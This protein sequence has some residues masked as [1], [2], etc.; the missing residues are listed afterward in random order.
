MPLRCGEC[1]TAVDETAET[2]PRCGAPRTRFREA[3][4]GPGTVGSGSGNA[5]PPSEPGLG[6]RHSIGVYTRAGIGV[7]VVAAAFM[8]LAYYSKTSHLEDVRRKCIATFELSRRCDCLVNEIDKHTSAIS[9]VPFLRFISGL[10]QYK[11][12]DIIREASMTCVE[13]R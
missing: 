4:P 10:T 11:L 9:F 13:S 2:C 12:G 8:A 3:E 5:L 1:R 7:V 6:G